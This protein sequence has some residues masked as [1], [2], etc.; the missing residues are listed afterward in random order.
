M[1]KVLILDFGGQYN[2]LIARRVREC[3]VYCE[4]HPAGEMDLEAIR[5]FAP[6][7]IILSGGPNSVYAENAPRLPQDI[8]SLGIPILGICYGCQLMAYQLGGTVQPAAPD[9]AR[10]YGRTLTNLD[11]SDVLFSDCGSDSITWMSHSDYISCVPEGFTVTAR[12]SVC[13]TAA[14]SCPER[15]LYGVQFHPEV[16]HTTEGSKMIRRF[17]RTVCGATC[18]WFMENVVQTAVNHLRERIGSKRVLLA[19]SGGVDSSVAAALLNRAVG[20][21]LTCIFVDHGMLRQDEGDQVEA[22]FSRMDLHFIRVNA[23][24]QFL[25]RL[26]GVTDPEEKRALIG[27]E[28]IRVFEAEAKKLGCVDFLAQGTIYPDIIESGLGYADV[29]KSHHNVGALP[30]HIDFKELIEPLRLLFKDEVRELGR[31][32]GLPETLVNRQPFPGPGLAIR[33]IGQVTPE[34]I[35]I[36]QKADYIFRTEL[37]KAHMNDL[38]GQ[39]FAVLTDTRTVGVMG[40]E[41]SYDYTLALRAVTTDDFMTA[42]WARIP[43]ELL[44]SISGLIINQVSGINRIVYD[45][46]N[47]PP[48]TIEWE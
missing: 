13:P 43:Y 16:S 25:T 40:D 23:A 22:F 27:E 4:V 24:Q 37:E 1:Q 30:D 2:Q 31:T 45:I 21:Q 5:S 48:A 33:I 12:T 34:K 39:Y 20:S 10:E 32:M 7:G 46:T 3:H 44:D 11:N 47:K 6:I 41:R 18:D 9:T 29:I 35:A 42:K 17:L 15:K 8:F 26:S 19:L 36:L 28:F 14:F 38:I